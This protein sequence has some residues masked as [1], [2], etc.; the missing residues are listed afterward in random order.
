[1]STAAFNNELK[2]NK[3]FSFIRLERTHN[4]SESFA[5]K[6]N[7]MEYLRDRE[8]NYFFPGEQI[9]RIKVNQVD[10]E[11]LKNFGLHYEKLFKGLIDK[12]VKMNSKE[13]LLASLYRDVLYHL[14]YVK[15]TSLNEIPKSVQSVFKRLS[16]YVLDDTQRQPF[17]ITGKMG[18]G[19]SSIIATFF[20]N[21]FMQLSNSDK[22][23]V[24]KH[25][26]VIRFIGMDG[27]TTYL[28]TLLKSLCAQLQYVKVNN[29]TISSESL[30][31]ILPKRMNELKTFFKRFLT[32]NFSVDNSQPAKKLVLILDSLQDLTKSDNSYK[33]D[34]LPRYLNPYC[35]LILTVSSESIELI[36]RLQRKYTNKNNYANLEQLNTEQVDY[37]IRKMLNLKNYRLETSQ[38]GVISKLIANKPIFPLH[39]KLLSENFLRWKSYTPVEECVLKDTLHESI[40]GLINELERDI[41][42]LF[43]KHALSILN[44]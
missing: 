32:E 38:L 6:I 4:S 36:E 15:F 20:S 25:T 30:E 14:N 28:R 7:T 27:E 41:G 10:D 17:V 35:K 18:S 21:L 2:D 11:Y 19:K 31:E 42:Y 34:W 9:Y 26:I 40:L 37:L 33:L 8:I 12:F 39:V 22:F 1:M 43:V 23:S 3:M 29:H 16:D 44:F 5:T 13:T 24:N